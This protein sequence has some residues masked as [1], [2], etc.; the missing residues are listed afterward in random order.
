MNTFIIYGYAPL[1]QKFYHP[2]LHV[3]SLP[4]STRHA[5]W[6]LMDRKTFDRRSQSNP[7][8]TSDLMLLLDH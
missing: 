5:A 8:W 7:S 4:H 2:L 6:T 1:K 3:P